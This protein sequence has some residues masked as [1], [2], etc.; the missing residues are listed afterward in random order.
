MSRDVN[1]ALEKSSADDDAAGDYFWQE[2]AR[3][4]DDVE[5]KS[6]DDVDGNF[7]LREWLE[8]SD[9]GEAKLPD[10]GDANEYHISYV[11][12]SDVATLLAHLCDIIRYWGPVYV[13]L[14]TCCMERWIKSMKGLLT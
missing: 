8:S 1:A 2:W 14:W 6:P 9:D 11:N 5:A 13:F 7:F 3:R 12:G 10:E 4:G